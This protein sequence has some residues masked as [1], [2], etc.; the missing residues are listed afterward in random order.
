MLN[1]RCFASRGGDCGGCG[2]EYMVVQAV[3]M[4]GGGGGEGSRGGG[5]V[6]C[7]GGRKGLF[8]Q[9]WLWCWGRSGRWWG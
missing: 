4:F 1:Y 5:G 8:V 7:G 9:Q 2:G 3:V 6:L